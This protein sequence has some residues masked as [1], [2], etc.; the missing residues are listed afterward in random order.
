LEGRQNWLPSTLEGTSS[1]LELDTE[2]RYVWL[3][4]WGPIDTEYLQDT[5]R[6]LRRVRKIVF[7]CVCIPATAME[8]VSSLYGDDLV[9]DPAC[10]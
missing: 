6:G 8:P 7:V 5:C 3:V 2:S 1:Q 10:G 9:Y 4:P